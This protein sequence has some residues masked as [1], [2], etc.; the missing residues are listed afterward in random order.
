MK[1]FMLI[2]LSISVM[3]SC[4]EIIDWQPEQ[5]A[6]Q[7]IV[8]E[9]ILTDEL[10]HQEI[11][12]SGLMDDINGIATGISGAEIAVMGDDAIHQFAEDDFSPGL[13]R[14]LQPFRIRVGK[15][16]TLEIDWNDK[17]IEA[18][19]KAV[20]SLPM[21]QFGIAGFEQTDSVF[22]QGL[23]VDYSAV[24]QAM[25]EFEIDWSSIIPSGKNRARLVHYIFSSINIGQLFGPE[26]DRLIF[27][28]GSTIVVK[29]YALN[30][31]FAEY[32][33]SL[34]VE[35]QWKGGFFEETNGN[36]PTNLSNGALGYFAVC[37]VQSDTLIAQ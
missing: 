9:G 10:V 7:K 35:T 29:K 3:L 5:T 34:V 1:R 15:L 18:E 33:R 28:K 37:T 32:L 19:A 31:G 2:I 4:E 6:E 16:Y 21:R 20:A 17:Q 30:E 8:I 23:G 11:R 27:P 25:Y 36:L 12:L 22:I 24:E 13:Y 14:S 26:K